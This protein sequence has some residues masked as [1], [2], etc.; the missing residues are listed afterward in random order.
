MRIFRSLAEVPAD[1]GPSAITI[2]NF[3]G[4]HLGHRRILKRVRELAAAN[5]WRPSVLTFDPHPTAVVAPERS[6][7]LLTAP[8]ERVALMAEE[9]IEQALILPFDRSVAGLSPEEFASRLL[10]DRLGTR[11]VL[12][13]DN[14]RF[15]KNQSGNAAVL[16]ELGAKLGFT[17]EIVDAVAWRGQVV[18][19]SAIRELVRSGDVATAARFLRR[20]YALEGEVVSGRRVGSRQ[21]VPTLNLATPAAMIPARGVYLTRT[22]DL[23]GS[24]RWNSL[25][26]VGYRP[27]FGESSRLSIET[28]LLDDFS[29][30]A[31]ARIAVEFLKRVRAEVRFDSPEE[32]KA[33]IQEDAAIATRFFRRLKEWRRR[34]R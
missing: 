22:R 17:V 2:G 33:R 19:S 34:P 8:E 18:S 4:V 26:N 16:C 7:R 5:G 25:T 21:T 14:F 30:D 31:P 11:A 24:R 27:T 23:D 9:G 15:G 6:P 3:D 28:Y 10:V 1:F 32:L 12:V 29:G 13:G 20:P